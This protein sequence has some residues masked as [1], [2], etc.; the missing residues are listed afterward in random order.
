M[1][2]PLTPQS[3]AALLGCIHAGFVPV[4]IAESFAPA[5]IE[6]RLNIAG[7]RLLI[8]QDVLVRDGKQLAC[9]AKSQAI[10][11]LDRVIVLP[12]QG[13][14]AA[15]P[16]DGRTILCDMLGDETPTEAALAHS[17]S[18][19]TILFSS[20]TTGCAESDSLDAHHA[21][22]VR[23]RCALASQH[24][25]RQRAV[26]AY[27]PGLDDGPLVDLRRLYQSREHRRV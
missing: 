12:H 25:Q 6:T 19:S 9:Y 20:G 21:D 22:Q 7:A 18:P 2:A 23:L 3:I 4:A 8:T 5:E 16:V 17:R 1:M 11:C 24:D 27:Q 26:L 14:Q 10:E 15:V 13:D